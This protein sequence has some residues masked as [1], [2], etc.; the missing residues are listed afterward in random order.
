MYE[1]IGGGRGVDALAPMPLAHLMVPAAAG[2]L[3]S[4]LM[5]SHLI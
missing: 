4:S 3:P 2:T 5:M 1:Y